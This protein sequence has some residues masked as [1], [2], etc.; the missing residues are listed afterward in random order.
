MDSNP[1]PRSLVPQTEKFTI[2]LSP[3]NELVQRPEAL[4]TFTTA[5]RTL[6]LLF[7]DTDVTNSIKISAGMSWMEYGVIGAT[8]SVEVTT[9]CDS[10]RGVIPDPLESKSGMTFPSCASVRF[11]QKNGN[12]YN[13]K[14]RYTKANLKVLGYRDLDAFFGELD[15]TITFSTRFNFD[16]DLSD[17]VTPEST[18]LLS[19]CIHEIMHLCGFISGLDNV[20][21][22]APDFVPTLLDFARFRFSARG[23]DFY[24][25]I[26][27][28]NPGVRRHMFYIDA[29]RGSNVTGI[30]LSS[31]YNTGDGNQA[32][33]WGAN[34]M[35]GKYIGAMDPTLSK[36]DILSITL[37]DLFAFRLLGYSVNLS[38]KPIVYNIKVS[39]T[40]YRDVV[41]LL[42]NFILSDIVKCDYG[43]GEILEASSLDGRGMWVCFFPNERTCKVRLLTGNG[44]SSP[45]IGFPF[46][47]DCH[48]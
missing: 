47:Q 32:S 5:A 31:G 11:E 48:L 10:P 43:N 33:H 45:W 24:R 20:D 23:L 22:G 27:L 28:A 30:T 6:E 29:F 9:W 1:T 37:N 16:T 4:N 14:I 13:Q 44:A 18:D 41:V 12:G 46:Y 38:V 21:Y 7:G 35:Y 15:G 34:E 26:R 36:G 3:N 2:S 8:H 40:G 25:D 42:A 19:V 17:G 39:N